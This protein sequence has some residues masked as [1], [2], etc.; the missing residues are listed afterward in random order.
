MMAYLGTERNA[1]GE[2]GE[3]EQ[4]GVV[5]SKGLV[6]D[7]GM[8]AGREEPP[9]D[10][11]DER[12]A[13]RRNNKI[14]EVFPGREEFRCL[15]RQGSVVPVYC[16]LTAD[17]ETP[18][19]LFQ[20]VAGT[21]PIA[22]ILESVEAGEKPGRYSFIGSQP[23]MT[24]RVQGE[25]LERV[26]ID[27]QG[28]EIREVFTSP[29]PL[30]EI[31][32][33]LDRFQPVLLPG[34]PPFF[35]GAV[36]YVGYEAAGYCEPILKR[37]GPDLGTDPEPDIFM[38]FTDY[39]LVFDHARH[40]VKVIVN[41]RTGREEAERVYQRSREK[42]EELVLRIRCGNGLD[43]GSAGEAEFFALPE[44]RD[45]LTPNMTPAEFERMVNKAK[46]HIQAGDIFQ[47]VLSQRFTGEL[48][49]PPFELYRALRM[50]N[51]SPYLFY[52][53][54]GDIQLI[55]SSPE[56]HVRVTGNRVWMRPIAG[57]RKR[58]GSPREDEML[59]RELLSDEKELAEHVML[60]DLARNDLGKLCEYG[61]VQVTGF[62]TIERYSHVMHIV[63]GVQGE[64]HP[65]IKP[66]EVLRATFP[67]GTVSGAP[68]IRAMQ[69]IADLEPHRRGPYSGV[70]GYFGFSGN[71]DVCITIRTITVREGRISIQAGAGIVADS[72]PR[73]EYEETLNKAR[74]MVV[75]CRRAE[76]RGWYI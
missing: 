53:D 20:K 11:S 61:S 2:G 19:S 32:R 38:M 33:E 76:K 18:V 14:L 50:V 8:V 55:G 28:E 59:E 25:S 47:V 45:T 39:V 71:L 23:F 37:T 31:Q 51:P 74:G 3:R 56:S 44:D 29:D 1:V 12:T 22:F 46:E 41:A 62:S 30:A 40:T 52:L 73:K 24:M 68:K 6:L 15:A 35:G 70:V 7:D 10:R 64:L 5:G 65:G 36:G 66:V 21:T 60:V 72:D 58:G 49:C 75:A 9:E 67:A 26:E 4:S 27:D 42:L 43:S 54:C 57:T 69:I 16:E 17:L 48:R 13:V 63:S 34:L